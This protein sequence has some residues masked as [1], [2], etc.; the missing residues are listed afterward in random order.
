MLCVT[1]M[2]LRDIT[3]TIFVIVHL[4]LF[5]FS[6]KSDTCSRVF[7]LQHEHLLSL[8]SIE[9]NPTNRK[10]RQYTVIV[11]AAYMHFTKRK[12]STSTT[13]WSSLAGVLQLNK[14]WI[15]QP[16]RCC[17]AWWKCWWPWWPVPWEPC[18]GWWRSLL[19]RSWSYI[20]GTG[21]VCTAPV[22]GKE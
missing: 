8:S 4:S 13:L 15:H 16:C 5:L 17:R 22:N 1:G 11:L 3:N 9:S 7:T 12:H 2:Y 6:L 21:L 14:L 18:P 10:H 19:A 20:G